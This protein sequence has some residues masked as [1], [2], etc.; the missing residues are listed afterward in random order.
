ML[1]ENEEKKEDDELIIKKS[2]F[3]KKNQNKIHIKLAN[4]RFYNGIVLDVGEDFIILNEKELDE[5]FVSFKEI[6]RIDPF[7]EPS[8]NKKEVGDGRT[9]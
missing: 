5:I 6:M 9:K 2:N 8:K 4:G 3:Y 7:T 1:N